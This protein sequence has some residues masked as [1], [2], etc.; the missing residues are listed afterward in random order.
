M[1]TTYNLSVDA[2]ATYT[3]E[4]EY[5]NE[6]GSIF[7]LTGYTAKMQVREMP[8]SP[9]FVL[10]VTPVLTI[11]TGIISV[12]L[13]AVQTAT[14]TNSKYVYAIELY[15]SAGYVIRA[16]EGTIAVSPEVVR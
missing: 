16:V 5:T 12:T 1:A 9:A 15:G 8:S 14:L 13:T 10:E 3:V 4:F 11:Q 2:G 6:D 7:D